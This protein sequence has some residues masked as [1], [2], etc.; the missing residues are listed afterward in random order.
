[1]QKKG[2]EVE[3]LRRRPY[4]CRKK[5]AVKGSGDISAA[6]VTYICAAITDLLLKPVYR[7]V[8]SCE[9]HQPRK[10]TPLLVKGKWMKVP[11]CFMSPCV[12]LWSMSFD[13]WICCLSQ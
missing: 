8:F 7:K 13:T 9:V 2:V 4:K 5:G 1:M 10:L 6:R 12:G 3:M 11:V